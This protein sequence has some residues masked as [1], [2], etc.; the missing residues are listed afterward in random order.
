MRQAMATAE[1]AAAG[2]NSWTKQPNLGSP[3]GDE[4]SG[5]ERRIMSTYEKNSTLYLTRY[6]CPLATIF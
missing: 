6:S 3:H 5:A 1:F 2:S 4:I